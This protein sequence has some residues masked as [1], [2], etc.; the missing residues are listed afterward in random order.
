MQ[1]KT[2]SHHHRKIGV[3][4]GEWRRG[5]R[6]HM[7]HLIS[8][9]Q[10]AGRRFNVGRGHWAQRHQQFGTPCI[11]AR[12]AKRVGNQCLQM[13]GKGGN[14]YQGGGVWPHLSRSFAWC[15]IFTLLGDQDNWALCGSLLGGAWSQHF[16]IVIQREP[17]LLLK[18][19]EMP[20]LCCLSCCRCC[21]D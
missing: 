13:G 5:A 7:P 8:A 11:L 21:L 15:P 16:P 9:P 17:Q 12:W 6:R 3:L 19:P 20:I 1:L 2:Y 14:R 4:H 18:G 10:P